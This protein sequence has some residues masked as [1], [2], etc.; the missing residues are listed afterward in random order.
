MEYRIFPFAIFFP[1]SKS[2]MI[3]AF[4]N[5][6][7]EMKVKKRWVDVSFRASYNNHETKHMK[8]YNDITN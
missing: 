7:W 2:E 3:D 1:F 6:Y 5:G 4:V 8:K